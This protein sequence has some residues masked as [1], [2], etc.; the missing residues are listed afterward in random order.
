MPHANSLAN[1][2]P[3]WQS[4]QQPRPGVRYIE[5]MINRAHKAGPQAIRLL[6]QAMNDTELPMSLRCRC[7]E[8]IAD[9]IWPK[10][11]PELRLGDGVE[12]LELRF[13]APGAS[14]ASETRRIAFDERTIE[15]DANDISELAE[16]GDE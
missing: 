8:Y 10:S 16:N 14:A 11:A 12:F 6:T 2:R 3:P 9:K 1:L 4:G 7:A 15:A 5:R 13:V